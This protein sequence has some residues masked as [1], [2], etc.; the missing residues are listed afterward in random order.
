[1]ALKRTFSLETFYVIMDFARDTVDFRTIPKDS[2]VYN[3]IF[4]VYIWFGTYVQCAQLFP[5]R[6]GKDLKLE[7]NLFDRVELVTRYEG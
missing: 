1:M 3:M 2:L 6:E 5:H 7:Q 4:N